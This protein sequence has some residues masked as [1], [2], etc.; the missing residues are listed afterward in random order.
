MADEWWRST[1]SQAIDR[2]GLGVEKN[3]QR[4]RH[5]AKPIAVRVDATFDEI[6]RTFIDAVARTTGVAVT[7]S[8]SDPVATIPEA[9]I[10]S[11]PSL[12]ARSEGI[13]RV[14]WLSNETAPTVELLQRGISIDPRALAQRGDVETARWLLE[15]S[16]SITHHRYGNVNAG[17]KPTC[18]GLGPSVFEG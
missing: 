17:P 18:E 15:Q 6:Q 4:Y 12:V 10:E 14:R 3:F 9:V 11:I 13:D 8:A 1:G 5:H 2:T 7:F 16:V